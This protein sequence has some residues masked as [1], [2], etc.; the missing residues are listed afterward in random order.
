MCFGFLILFL[1]PVL[2]KCFAGNGSEIMKSPGAEDVAVPH[3]C[4]VRF[5]RSGH[6][7]SSLHSRSR[8]SV[9]AGIQQLSATPLQKGF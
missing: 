1:D 6:S 9:E 5:S 4:E 2:K 7:E 3:Q 8:K